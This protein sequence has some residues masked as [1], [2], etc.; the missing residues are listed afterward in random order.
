MW[1]KELAGPHVRSCCCQKCKTSSL[2]ASCSGKEGL[3]HTCAEL[4]LMITTLR[5]AGRATAVVSLVSASAHPHYLSHPLPQSFV[6][7]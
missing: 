2:E 5:L 1:V 3:G 6:G 4:C 7:S